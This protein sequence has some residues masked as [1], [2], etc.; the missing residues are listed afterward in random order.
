MALEEIF[1]GNDTLIALDEVTDRSGN[2]VDTATVE[3]NMFDANN[4]LVP[5]GFFPLNL[6]NVSG[7]R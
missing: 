5:G 6:P 4:N 3:A 7:G 1:L 2:L